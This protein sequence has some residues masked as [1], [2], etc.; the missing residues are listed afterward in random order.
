MSTTSTPGSVFDRVPVSPRRRRTDIAMRGL[1]AAATCVALVPL[2]L[3][4]YYLLHKGLGTFGS[5]FFTTAPPPGRSF[6]PIPGAPPPPPCNI[7]GIRSAVFGT[8]EIVGIAV[9]LA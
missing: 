3:I 4:I 5:N 2:V 9:V 7:G 6:P 1:L 8:L